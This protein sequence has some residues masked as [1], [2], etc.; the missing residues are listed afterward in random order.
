[1]S[2]T[3]T[4]E[5]AR[6]AESG[7][8]GSQILTAGGLDPVADAFQTAICGATSL[9]QAQS[10]VS[11][12]GESLWNLAVGRAQ[13]TVAVAGTLPG[14]DDR[15]LYW[16]RLSM[17]LTLRRWT[18]GFT[19][20]G[21]DR[22]ALEESL[23]RASRGMTQTAFPGGA[24]RTTLFLSGFDPFSLDSDERQGNPS[25]SVALSLDGREW[26]GSD[27]HVYQAQTVVFPVRYTDF[28][29]GMVEDVYTPVFTAGTAHKA[30]M[31]VTM[32]QG[33]PGLFDL[34][35]YNGRR[36]STTAPDNNNLQ[37]GGSYYHPVVPPSVGAGPEFVPTT[38]PVTTMA[39]AANYQPF[40]VRV[41]TTVVE[42]PAGR[43][44]PVTRSNGPTSGST[45]VEGGGGG[46]LSNEI[47]YRASLLRDTVGT[48][49]VGGH[50]HTPVLDFA[51]GDSTGLTDPTFEQNRENILSQA[52]ILIESTGLTF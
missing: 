40:H 36:R 27:G 2:A 28:N 35:V 46:Y 32:S 41:H 4:V 7:S 23:E 50:I 18:P 15:P 10:I 30:D 11:Q 21:N 25:G 38:L 20:S 22:A 3:P 43:W 9:A 17:A 14:D 39:G 45:A 52:H 5:E 34:E 26:T 19:L 31:Y 37:G 49:V 33:R 47:A 6:L 24:G 16:A 8:V 12:Q 48:G 42:I 51:S 29:E 44:W 1:M 13:G